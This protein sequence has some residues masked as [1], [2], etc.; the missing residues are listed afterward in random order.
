MLKVMLW[1]DSDHYA[2]SVL[3]TMHLQTTLPKS[4]R[5]ETPEVGKSISTK[6]P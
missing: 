5:K 1:I 4:C 2:G 3:Q 6:H